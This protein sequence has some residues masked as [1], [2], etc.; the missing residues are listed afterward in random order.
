MDAEKKYP[1][2]WGIYYHGKLYMQVYGKKKAHDMLYRLSMSIHG[3]TIQP[4]LP[5][6]ATHE[7]AARKK[8]VDKMDYYRIWRDKNR[9]KIRA[10]QREYYRKKRKVAASAA[11]S[12]H[13]RSQ[14]QD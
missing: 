5:D 10:Y 9:D 11:A 8:T 6:E 14:S 12:S 13:T 7:P 4:I 3:L 1:L 2:K